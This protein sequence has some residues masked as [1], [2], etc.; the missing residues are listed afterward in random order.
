MVVPTTGASAPITSPTSYM[1][2]PRPTSTLS[3]TATAAPSAT[4]TSTKTTPE[5][6]YWLERPISPEGYD[7][8][9]RFYPYASRAD[10]TY[11][12]HHGVE[13]VNPMGTP[14]LATAPGTILV[15]GDDLTQVY[16]A[17]TDFYGLLI[18]E[19]LER[20]FEGEPVYVLYGHLS[21]IKVREGEPVGTGD[22]I[23][24][25]GA[26]GVAEGPHLH[27]EVRVGGNDYGATV[28]PELWVRPHEGH[29]TLAGLLLSPEGEP[30][31]EA[32]IILSRVAAPGEVAVEII[33]YP[34]K[35]VNP[36]PAWGENFAI[37]DL[38]AGEWLIEVYRN[39][40]L[41]TETVTIK[42]GATT[43]LRLRLAR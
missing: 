16:G 21:E 24:L 7:S 32:K 41:Y 30:V 17:R 10:G 40:R 2:S 38:E 34:D 13:F 42:A 25:V 5:D 23:G 31:I 26:T 22:V 20:R 18:V 35:E 29:G 19:Q 33:T 1:P 27:M 14:I 8:V 43:W 39:Q 9:A 36:D 4:P 3:A 15:A 6:H 37:G 28:N 12:I 11:P